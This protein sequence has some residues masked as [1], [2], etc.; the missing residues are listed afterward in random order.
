MLLALTQREVETN[1]HVA[2]SNCALDCIWGRYYSSV[3]V[4]LSSVFLRLNRL[5]MAVET[6]FVVHLT[7]AHCILAHS[8]VH[9]TLR[10]RNDNLHRWGL[11]ASPNLSFAG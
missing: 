10:P 2:N 8:P 7:W 1:I 3:W 4:R 6:D 11:G 5:R 9:P